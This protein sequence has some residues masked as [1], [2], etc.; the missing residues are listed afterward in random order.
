M[1]LQKVILLSL[2]WSK[3]LT[4]PIFQETPPKMVNIVSSWRARHFHHFELLNKM[5]RQQTL[6]QWFTFVGGKIWNWSNL[7]RE[8]GNINNNSCHRWHTEKESEIDPVSAF[9]APPHTMYC[10]VLFFSRTTKSCCFLIVTACWVSL[11]LS[12]QNCI[13][14][15]FF[16]ALFLW[17]L[18][19]MQCQNG[20]H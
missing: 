20:I 19:T 8:R 18:L 1:T 12:S 15:F 9:E 4:P 14:F 6:A 10:T 7:S 2:A 3:F 13:F 11:M 17:E 16:F 5:W